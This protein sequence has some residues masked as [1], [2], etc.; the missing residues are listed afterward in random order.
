MCGLFQTRL[1][2]YAIVRAI[3]TGLRW[4]SCVSCCV[5]WSGWRQL[6][7]GRMGSVLTQPYHMRGSHVNSLNRLAFN[8]THF[9][10]EHG[11][12]ICQQHADNAGLYF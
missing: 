4:R 10:P 11:K 2:S 5:T 8:Y 1:L 9:N 6:W 7:S 12:N 3:L